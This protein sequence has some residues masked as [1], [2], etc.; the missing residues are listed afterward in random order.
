MCVCVTARVTPNKGGV[1]ISSQAS[2]R[3]GGSISKPLKVLDT[4]KIL[5]WVPTGPETKLDSAD[6]KQKQSIIVIDV[7]LISNFWDTEL[8]KMKI[9][10]N[11]C[12]VTRWN[13]RVLHYQPSSLPLQWKRDVTKLTSG[14][15]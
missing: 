9:I 7:K 4:V 5:S 14:T 6:E 13:V 8:Y 1:T 12:L 11:E 15:R 10:M 2:H 3:G